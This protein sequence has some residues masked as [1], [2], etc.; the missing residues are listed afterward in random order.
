MEQ[1]VLELL[2]AHNF[3]ITCAESCTGGLI[4]GRLVNASGISEFYEAGVV[5][6]ANEAK[7]RFLKVPHEMLS[8]Y[9]AVSPQVAQAMAE[10]ALDFAGADVSIAVTGIAGPGGGSEE[11]PVGL[12]YIACCVRGRVAL[13]RHIFSGNRTQVRESTVEAALALVVKCLEKM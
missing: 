6:Y 4:S 10:G 1:R 2:R 12:V 9:G 5:T 7:E 3:K 13:E 11:K 8:K